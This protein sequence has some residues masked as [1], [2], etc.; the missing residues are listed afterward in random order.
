[1]DF[2]EEVNLNTVSN[3]ELGLTNLTSGSLAL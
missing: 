1:M 3:L 2:E